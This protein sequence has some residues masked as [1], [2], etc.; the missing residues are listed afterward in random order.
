M[1]S[2]VARRTAVPL[3][4]AIA[5]SLMVIVSSP[6]SGLLK[7][8]A[9]SPAPASVLA[10]R[11][12]ATSVFHDPWDYSNPSDQVMDNGPTLGLSHKSMSGGM[13]NFVTHSG[14]I[15]PLWSGYA[16]EVPVE[17]E[18]I[19]TGN[20]VDAHTYTR[21][22]I[23][24]YVSANA[25][26]GLSWYTCGALKHGCGGSMNV[27][28]RT[29]WNDIDVKIVGRAGYKAWA[30]H[31]VGL[32]LAMLRPS[33]NV[34]VHLDSLRIYQSTSASVFSWS[35]TGSHSPATLWWTDLPGT[36]KAVR[37][38][39]AG[40]VANAAISDNSSSRVQANVAG[41]APGT[42][43]WSVAADGT[44][45]L[46]GTTKAAP[47]PV[48]DSP[49]A[50]GCG[51]YATKYL[52]HPWTFHSGRS[53]AGHAN[54][55]RISFSPSGEL[56]ATNAAPHINDPNIS[57]P[58]ARGGIN[59]KLYHRLTIVESYDGA[60][61]LRNAPG[62][63]TMA[64]VLWQVPGHVALSQTAPLVTFTGKRTITVD[65]AT[66]TNLLT[67]RSGTSAMRYAFASSSRVTRLRYDPNEDRGA[68]RWHVY[69]IRLAADCRATSSFTVGWH[70][71]HYVAGTT[72]KLVA[73]STTG[74][75]YTLATGSEHAGANHRA[76]ST[77]S[78]PRGRYSVIVYATS[79]GVTTSAVSSGPLV[80]I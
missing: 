75:L 63:G 50:A 3:V 6:G 70:D 52:G 68:R 25:A 35:A 56:S 4:L 10:G 72:V 77:R 71:T 78:L 79:K 80:R 34:T 41:F 36:I 74:H 21:L 54:M 24:I 38:Q 48:V 30:G 61:D 60:F 47:L 46:V 31:L 7:S 69:S 1:L 44:K 22:H 39:H 11:D 76:V 20:S 40:P 45:T 14:Y 2:R 13:L 15:S 58:I 12:Y 28:F 37:G 43:F 23:H 66:P 55:S 49:T 17:R 64:R 62:G 42:S 73:R 67:D 19:K 26:A 9:A 18:G 32:R 16:N 8:A 33:G 51:D 27:A 65:M 59:G 53:L 29:G 57:L 5:A